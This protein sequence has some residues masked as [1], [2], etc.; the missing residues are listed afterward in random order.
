M[1]ALLRPQGVVEVY[2]AHAGRLAFRQKLENSDIQRVRMDTD[3]TLIAF[4]REGDRVDTI[5]VESGARKRSLDLE[6]A[7]GKPARTPA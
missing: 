5:V 1:F 3:G 6:M 2:D 4:S 7:G